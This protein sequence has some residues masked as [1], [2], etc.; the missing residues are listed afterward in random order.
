MKKADISTTTYE[1]GEF[2]VDIVTTGDSYEAW[3]Y[4][5]EYG[6]KVLMFGSYRTLNT[7]EEFLET[8]EANIDEYA[9]SYDNEYAE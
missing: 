8:V 6:V 3:L 4:R 5:K 9:E 2:L 7:L 1:C